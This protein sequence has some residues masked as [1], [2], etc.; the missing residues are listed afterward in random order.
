MICIKWVPGKANAAGQVPPTYA[1]G[2]FSHGTSDHRR[3]Q[4]R[5]RTGGGDG[6]GVRRFFRRLV[7]GPFRFKPARVLP[8]SWSGTGSRHRRTDRLVQTRVTPIREMVN[9]WIGFDWRSGGSM[10]W[11]AIGAD[12]L[13]RRTVP[14]RGIHIQ[15]S[16]LLCGPTGRRHR[17]QRSCD[18]VLLFQ[19]VAVPGGLTGN[20]P[21]PLFPALDSVHLTYDFSSARYSSSSIR[22]SSILDFPS[23]SR[24][25]KDRHVMSSQ[26]YTLRV[27]PNL[28][29]RYSHSFGTRGFTS[30]L[31][32]QHLKNWKNRL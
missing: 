18:D 7:L 12:H 26:W 16:S 25:P 19:A 27:S 4:G 3:P 13:P 9:A 29:H 2:L 10:D 6:S 15:R 14:A 21:S 1:R 30:R 24:L 20:A 22:N 8:H 23:T 11:L 28:Y 5:L 17:G 31:R 32:E